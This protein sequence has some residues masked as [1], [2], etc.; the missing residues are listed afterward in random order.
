M[1]TPTSFLRACVV[2]ALLGALVACGG[3]EDTASPNNEQTESE[4]AEPAADLAKGTCWEDQQLPAALGEEEFAKWVE[5]Y[6]RGDT[7]L[8]ESMSNDAAF[9]N[10]VDCAEPHALEVYNVVEVAPQLE[11][12][13]RQ[14]ADLL[15]QDSRLYRRIRDQVNDRCVAGTPYAAAMGKL[16]VQLGPSLN[17]RSGLHLAWD[18]VPANRWEDGQHQFVCTFE[19]DRPGT[20][21]FTDL[22]TRKVPVDARVC[23]NVPGTFVP[24]RAPHQAE[25]IGHMFLN[26]AIE[27]RQIDA[28][29]ALRKGSDGPEVAFSEDEYARLDKVCQDLLDRVSREPGDI[30]AKVFPGSPKQWPTP[31][32]AYVASCF[33]LE[34]FDPPPK[35]RGTVF[36][37]G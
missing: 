7:G 2:A 32:G 21:R 12:Q 26:T 15:D 29:R 33:A 19:Q 13:V 20:L 36:N 3:G 35:V 17:P 24:C 8:A 14:Y 4:P 22:T 37:R 28:R 6:A 11:R 5:R 18:P 16:P 25:D 1:P 23:L 9:V 31:D 34:D 30:T 10:E 27:Q